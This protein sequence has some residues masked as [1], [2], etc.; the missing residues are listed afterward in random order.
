MSRRICVIPGDG[1]GREVIPVAQAVLEAAA[2]GALE[3]VMAEAG[4]DAFERHGVALPEETLELARS[5]DGILLG[6]VGSPLRRVKGYRSPVVALRQELDLYACVRPVRCA[7]TGVNLALVRESTEG[8]YSGIET[9]TAD[10]ATLTRVITREA[11]ERIARFAREYAL[12]H[13]FRRVTVVHKANVMRATCGLFRETVLRELAR[14]AE[15]EV[16]ERLVDSFAHDLAR[17]PERFQVVVTTNLF[18]DILSDLASVHAGGLG[19]AASMNLGS[20]HALFEPVHGSAPDIAG[21]GQAN[22]LACVGAAILLLRH[23]GL[24]GAAVRASQ[25]WQHVREHGPWCPDLGGS[26]TTEQVERA[27]QDRLQ[28]VSMS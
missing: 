18:G 28:E 21:M 25:A 2:P 19:L 15:L 14:S 5:A 6:A 4:W 20:A 12:E 23:L 13:G 8:M 1:I 22:P 9:S 7:S 24:D 26:A 16:E 3:F 17:E 11:S 27:L 10:R